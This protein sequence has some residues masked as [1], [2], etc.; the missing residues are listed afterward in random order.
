MYYIG[1]NK[2]ATA[3][4]KKIKIRKVVYTMK[5][6]FRKL[7]SSA[8]AL[9]L[10][11]S[12][13]VPALAAD[14]SADKAKSIALSNAGYKQSQVS[15]L[16]AELDYDDGVKYYDVSFYVKNSDGSYSEYDYDV[17]VSDGKIL[18]KDV[19]REGA[20][21]ASNSS[22]KPASGNNADIGVEAAKN[23]ALRHFGVKAA[24]VK[25]FNV[26]KDYDDGRA[27]YDVEFCKPYSV[28]Y[29]CD[30][31][32]SSGAVRDAEQEAVRGFGDKLELFFEVFFWNIFNK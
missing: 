22:S 10:V 18:S 5:K 23:A 11:F 12:L 31:V 9:L 29:S 24:D 27:V 30:V 25:F 20:K 14:I 26:K 6:N 3:Q 19:D 32:A 13:S 7:L 1:V 17:R 15:G 16:Y 8:L 4:F 28:K 21:P 2:R